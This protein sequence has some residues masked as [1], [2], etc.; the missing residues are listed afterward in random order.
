MSD[1]SYHLESE[2]RNTKNDLALRLA[3]LSGK[4]LTKEHLLAQASSSGEKGALARLLKVKTAL[5]GDTLW[6]P[7]DLAFDTLKGLGATSRLFYRGKKV[8]VDPFTTCQIYFEGERASPGK[9]AIPGAL[10]ASGHSPKSLLL[11]PRQSSRG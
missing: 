3:S 1:I 8:F 9:A 5:Q 11:G 2:K 4:P 6:V 10:E 7:S